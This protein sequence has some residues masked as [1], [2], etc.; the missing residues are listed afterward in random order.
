MATIVLMTTLVILTVIVLHYDALSFMAKVLP[1]SRLSHRARFVFGVCGATLIHII[2]I[3]LFGT[4]IYLV[5]YW[6]DLGS[7]TGNFD[8]SFFDSLYL[9]TTTYTSLGLGDIEPHGPIRL[10]LG[11]EA[12]T[13]LILITWTASFM[14]LG[15]Q[16]HWQQVASD[17]K[18]SENS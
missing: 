13:G 2:E 8:G 10:L 6:P 9:S 18:E 17:A 1:Q 11:L 14:F 5:K 12:L 4:C 15:M 16:M 3:A 7:Y